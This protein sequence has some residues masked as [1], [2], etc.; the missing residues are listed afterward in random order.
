ILAA[1]RFIQENG[2]SS[3]RDGMLR[4]RREAR[5]LLKP[6]VLEG[7]QKIPDYFYLSMLRDLL[8]H[9]QEHDLD[10]PE[11]K[12]YLDALGL[13]FIKFDHTRPAAMV[14]YKRMFP[15]DPEGANLDNWH[16]FEQKNP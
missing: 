7:I 10:I 6:E 9:V 5:Q 12:G 13:E 11:I 15:K 1:Q 8:F 4:F 3:D 2:Y 14:E 16:V